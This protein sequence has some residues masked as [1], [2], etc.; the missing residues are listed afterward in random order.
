[1]S[2]SNVAARRY[3]TAVLD[4]ATETGAADRLRLDLEAFQKQVAKSAELR[5][6][7]GNPAVARDALARIAAEVGRRM[8]LSDLAVSFLSLVASR[9]RLHDLPAILDAYA[10]EQD[11]RAGRGRGEVVSAGPVTPEQ[12]LKLRTALGK[13]LGRQLVLTQRQDPAILSGLR[14]S[15]GDRVYDLSARTWLDSLRSHLL[16]IR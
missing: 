5:D 15:V 7:V 9:R 12:V 11:R 13:A 16:E 1:M 8:A 4:V 10:E 14:V 6:T 3:A 2:K